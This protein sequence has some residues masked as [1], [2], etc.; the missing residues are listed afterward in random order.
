MFQTIAGTTARKESPTARI[1]RPAS[2][3][4]IGANSALLPGSESASKPF[5]RAER[6]S[7]CFGH[8]G[9]EERTKIV[10]EEFAA[11]LGT[12]ERQKNQ[13]CHP[14]REGVGLSIRAAQRFDA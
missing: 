3:V 11:F 13:L 4:S 14:L 2:R 6:R 1:S 9:G 10:E 5:R 7:M 12:I 8:V